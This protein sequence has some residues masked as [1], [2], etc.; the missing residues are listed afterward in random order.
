MGRKILAG[1]KGRYF[2][3]SVSGHL[4]PKCRS[5]FLESIKLLLNNANNPGGLYKPYDDKLF[6][7]AIDYMVDNGLNWL[8]ISLNK[9]LHL[10][11]NYS[12]FT[13]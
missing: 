7:A 1:S 4:E 10:S 6:I 12:L 11:I 8:K 2:C 5:E 9:I 3:Q 13:Q